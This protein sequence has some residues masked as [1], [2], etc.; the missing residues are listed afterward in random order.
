MSQRANPMVIGLFVVVAAVFAVA[1]VIVFGSGKITESKDT[2]VLFFD[3]SI[4]GLEVGAPVNFRGV[5]VGEVARI[6]VNLDAKTFDIETPIYIYVYPQRIKILH[7]ELITEE[8]REEKQGIDRLIE[9]GMRAKLVTQSFVTGL[10]SIEIEMKPDS[11]LKLHGLETQYKEIPTI[12]SGIEKITKTLQKIEFEEILNSLVG[13]I[14]KIQETV[15]SPMVVDSIS[16]LRDTLR[17][18]RDVM[19]KVSRQ[20]DPLVE[21]VRGTSQDLRSM[22][23]QA[24]QSIATV[25]SRLEAS[26]EDLQSLTRNLDSKIDPVVSSFQ[27][28]SQSARSFLNQGT[29]TLKTTEGVIE[30]RGPLH[31]ELTNALQELS[32]AARSIRILSDYLARNPSALITGKKNQGRR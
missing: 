12:P 29:E 19:R 7:E 9:L 2:F 15:A 31:Y 1:G 27:D 22:A 28:T 10:K 30:K 11:Q 6:L 4:A 17:Y 20:I 32:A 26:L 21:E 3:E 13:T 14:K 8:A 24:S 18:S 16:A 23:V 25:E 5:P